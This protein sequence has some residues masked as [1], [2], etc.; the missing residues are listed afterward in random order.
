LVHLSKSF[1]TEHT[2]TNGGH[3]SYYLTAKDAKVA[4]A[5]S[6]T[7]VDHLPLRPCVLCVER[8]RVLSH[9]DLFRATLW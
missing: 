9:T 4:K 1:T 8:I 3:G 7:V 6:Q 5:A 2:D